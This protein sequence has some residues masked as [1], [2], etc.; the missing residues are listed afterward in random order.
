MLLFFFFLAVVIV[1]CLTWCTCILCSHKGTLPPF[2]LRHT[3]VKK[4]TGDKEFNPDSLE[5]VG[6]PLY[7][8]GKRSTVQLPLSYLIVVRNSYNIPMRYTLHL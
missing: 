5:K 1:F 4:I 8:M 6:L 2:G 7:N 3:Q